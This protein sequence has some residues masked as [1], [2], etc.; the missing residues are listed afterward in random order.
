M[1]SDRIYTPQRQTRRMDVVRYV[2]LVWRLLTDKRVSPWLKAVIPTLV[3]AY[4]LSPW[5][6]V[7][8]LI[9]VLGQLDD[10]AILLLGM[11]LFI[12]LCPKQ[13]VQEHLQ[14]GSAVSGSSLS[15]DDVIDATYRVIEEE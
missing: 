15:D 14:G 9:P 7:A 8:D 10:L 1:S 5:D 3:L 13:I 6:L 11:Q 12:G 4:V 2:R